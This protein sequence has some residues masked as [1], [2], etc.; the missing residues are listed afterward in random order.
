MVVLPQKA[1]WA[2]PVTGR[3]AA[4][5]L[6]LVVACALAVCAPSARGAGELTLTVRSLIPQPRYA[7]PLWLELDLTSSHERVL[8]GRLQMTLRDEYVL[9]RLETDELALKKGAQTYRFLLPAAGSYAGSPVNATCRFAAQGATY[10]LGSHPVFTAGG[11]VRSFIVGVCLPEGPGGIPP[12]AESLLLERFDPKPVDRLTATSKTFLATVLAGDIPS[13]PLGCCV[14]DILFI[15]SSAL[16]ELR[17]RQVDAVRRW[18]RAGGSLCVELYPDADDA[19]LAIV[20][21]L[22]G[23]GAAVRQTSALG[24]GGILRLHCG[25]GRA[26]LCAAGGVPSFDA[27]SK[28]WRQAVA[29]LWKLSRE[30]QESFIEEGVWRDDLF[31]GQVGVLY[32]YG[33]RGG[34]LSR[35]ISLMAPG[36]GVAPRLA[37]GLMPGRVRLVPF[38]LVAL[39]LGLFVAAVGPLD[40]LLLGLLHRRKYT[41][42]FFPVVSLGLAVALVLLSRHYIGGSDHRAAAVFVDVAADGQPVRWSRYGLAFLGSPRTEPV[43]LRHAFYAD[44]DTGDESALA[45]LT[46]AAHAPG[47]DRLCSAPETPIG[48]RYPADYTAR[49]F[50]AQWRPVMHREFSFEPPDHCPPLDWESIG[51][52]VAADP[53]D[54]GALLATALSEQ[55]FEG[56]LFHASGGR[57]TCLHRADPDRQPP[58]FIVT[59]LRETCSGRGEGLFGLV[60]QISPTGGSGFDDLPL[61]DVTDRDQ[62][63]IVA[64]QQVG[65]DYY[66]FRRVY[67]KES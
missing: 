1:R 14:F 33:S 65:P 63:M 55:G 47:A 66:I 20:G 12:L 29:F 51:A 36:C 31:L 27:Q 41:W 28:Q 50:V 21:E 25:L 23:A 61:L 34:G 46:S 15:T 39:L 19:L 8:T 67:H 2:A 58:A 26:V 32:Q 56:D 7:G 62:Y 10:E 44:V 43:R 37:D 6:A 40:Y 4:I 13:Q 52:A 64:V 11:S 3:A 16:R 49:R 9:A 22:T 60:H 38:G 17:A 53:E 35:Q 5:R 48:G 24:P 42:V 30:Q 54:A 18:V 59:T 57:L 45:G